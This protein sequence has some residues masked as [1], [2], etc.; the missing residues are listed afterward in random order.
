MTGPVDPV[1]PVDCVDYHTAARTPLFD[2][3]DVAPHAVVVAVG[4]HEPGARETD[5]AL[6]GRATVVVEDRATA[7]CPL[8]QLSSRC[9]QAWA[10][11]A[12][13]PS[14]SRRYS[15]GRLYSWALIR[16]TSLPCHSLTAV[17]APS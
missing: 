6:V 16:S 10:S 1:D 14:A 11:S 2:G 8:S 4:S 7:G 3:A 5:S 15:S 17:S 13:S 9:P 12:G